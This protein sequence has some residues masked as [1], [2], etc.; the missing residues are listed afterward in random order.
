MELQDRI[1]SAADYLLN[2]VSLRPSVGMV[3]DIVLR[4]I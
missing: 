4:V 3:L 2:R 1:R